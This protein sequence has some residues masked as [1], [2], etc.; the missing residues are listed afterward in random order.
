VAEAH[1]SGGRICHLA[2]RARGLPPPA[3][4][5]KPPVQLSLFIG[6]SWPWFP[7]NWRYARRWRHYPFMY[8]WLHE[9]F[10]F[11]G[12]G[13]CS[14]AS[15]R[16]CLGNRHVVHFRE[17]RSRSARPALLPC[18]TSNGCRQ[19]VRWHGS[20]WAVRQHCWNCLG[21]CSNLQPSAA[22]NA[23]RHEK[24]ELAR[25]RITILPCNRGR[26][27][28]GRCADGPH[29][30]DHHGSQLPMVRRSRR[31]DGARCLRVSHSV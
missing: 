9:I 13:T 24:M 12:K 20:V 8:E 23:R 7:G 14:A 29:I 31:R 16:Q 26:P 25:R 3:T 2:F 15:F 17:A 5:L 1:P 10:R 22:Q 6:P 4:V 30:C 19:V 11:A 27:G 18:A 28:R 21:A